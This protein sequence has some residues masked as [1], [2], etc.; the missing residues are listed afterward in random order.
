MQASNEIKPIAISG[1]QKLFRLNDAKDDASRKQMFARRGNYRPVQ[2]KVV[3][4]DGQ[5]KIDGASVRHRAKDFG[6]GPRRVL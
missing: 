4:E 2:T 5:Q 6:L 3:R 1:I